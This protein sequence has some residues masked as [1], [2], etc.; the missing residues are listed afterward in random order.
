MI[1][2]EFIGEGGNVGGAT[3]NGSALVPRRVAE[4]RPGVRD[5]PY[6]AFCRSAI[7]RGERNRG[8][9]A[10]VMEDQQNSVRISLAN[11]LECA[12]IVQANR[13]RVG[14]HCRVDEPAPRF[15]AALF[16]I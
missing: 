13:Q 15:M 4:S 14:T 6:P 11:R 2:T 12:A 8:R 1:D 7:E 16:H 3:G 10:P 9:R 5:E